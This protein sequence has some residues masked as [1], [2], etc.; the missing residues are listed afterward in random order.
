MRKEDGAGRFRRNSAQDPADR[1]LSISD[2]NLLS[3]ETGGDRS[4]L[5]GECF[6]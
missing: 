1:D 2:E 4:D 5:A 6:G 3:E